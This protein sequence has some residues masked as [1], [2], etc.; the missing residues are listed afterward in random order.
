VFFP[1]VLGIGYWVF[2][3]LYLVL[4]WMDV[5]AVSWAGIHQMKRGRAPKSVG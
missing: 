3:I 4:G 1:L 5:A 2:C